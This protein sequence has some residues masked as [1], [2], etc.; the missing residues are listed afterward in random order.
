MDNNNNNLK[1]SQQIP[2]TPL[3]PGQTKTGVEHTLLMG[4]NEKKPQPRLEIIDEAESKTKLNHYI[5]V[6]KTYR[7]LQHKA[8]VTDKLDEEERKDYQS[9]ITPQL[10]MYIKKTQELEEKVDTGLKYKDTLAYWITINPEYLEVDLDNLVADMQIKMQKFSKSKTIAY[11]LY[12][13]EQGGNNEENMGV[14]PH[15]HIL[16]YP[17]KTRKSEPCKIKANLKR[18]FPKAQI[19]FKSIGTQ[20]KCNVKENY[21][22]GKKSDEEKSEKSYLDTVWRKELGIPNY[23]IM[24]P[25]NI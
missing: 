14:H 3:W 2:A 5:K 25:V 18:Y 16:M 4:E 10:E 19:Y 11:G 17:D 9:Y 1:Q 6:I 20:E 8:Y 12:A 23:I 13:F 7:D 22:K 21:I 15:I 24:K